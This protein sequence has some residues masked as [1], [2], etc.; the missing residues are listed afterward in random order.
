MK[1]ET[2]IG[3][4]LSLK[5]LQLTKLNLIRGGDGNDGGTNGD[6]TSKN[7]KTKG[8]GLDDGTTVAP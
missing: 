7:C 8:T 6:T 3:K 1:K 5:K 4:K 2:N